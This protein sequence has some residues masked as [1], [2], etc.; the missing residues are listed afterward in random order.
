MEKYQPC[1]RHFFSRFKHHICTEDSEQSV[2]EKNCIFLPSHNPRTVNLILLLFFII[3]PAFFH[4]LI[5]TISLRL[6]IKNFFQKEF[7]G[8]SSKE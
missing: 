3:I 5:Y 4:P 1:Q 7:Q 2:L 6:R 8:H